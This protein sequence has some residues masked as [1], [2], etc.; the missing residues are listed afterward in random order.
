M[1]YVFVF[2]HGNVAVTN[3]PP[4]PSHEAD[5]PTPV[6]TS[7]PNSWQHEG[8]SQKLNNT[9]QKLEGSSGSSHRFDG[10]CNRLEGSSSA[11]H[12]SKPDQPF[13]R[14]QLSTVKKNTTAPVRHGKCRSFNVTTHINVM[15]NDTIQA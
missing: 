8:S 3:A 13:A 11:G 9:S 14:S 4:Y 6:Y 5:T 2:Y 10:S 15:Y 1:N 12:D 7:N